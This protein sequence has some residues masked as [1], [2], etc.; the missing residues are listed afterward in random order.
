MSYFAILSPN[1]TAHRS[2]RSICS[3]INAK[4]RAV[5]STWRNCISFADI[6]ALGNAWGCHS[7]FF[8][9]LW[10]VSFL[11]TNAKT[12]NGEAVPSTWRNCLFFVDL[13]GL[14]TAWGHHSD[15]F[16][17]FMVCCYTFHRLPPFSSSLY[18]S[19]CLHAR[20]L[21]IGW[22]LQMKDSM[23]CKSKHNN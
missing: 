11:F 15:L 16:S 23:Q 17:L 2:N 1:T 3:S 9:F 19:R 12:C 5:P 7:S 14:V 10:Y 21:L 6:L 20:L 13:L 8:H 22:S 4:R 18:S